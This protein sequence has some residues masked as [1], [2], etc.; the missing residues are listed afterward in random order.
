MAI[1]GLALGMTVQTTFTT[2]LS[3]I[4]VQK[5][6]RAS[7][8]IN[9]TRQVIQAIS[10]AVLATVLTSRIAPEVQAEVAEFQT[11]AATFQEQLPAGTEI[12][13][14][15]D[16]PDSPLPVPASAR[17]TVAQFCRE[18]IVG[19][20]EAYNLTFYF[21]V[22]AV[23]LGLLLP[24]WPAAWAGRRAAAPGKAPVAAGH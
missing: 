1:R 18:Y 2:A 22:A 4:P 21:A 19:L 7:G 3:R 17:A 16:I 5:V 15:C 10:V 13:A 9:S 8:L 12:P 11:R 20:E 23:F 6:S 24:G 14:L